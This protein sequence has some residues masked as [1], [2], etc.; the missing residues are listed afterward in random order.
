MTIS[1]RRRDLTHNVVHLLDER[2]PE[3]VDRPVR[4]AAR[5]AARR[6]Q[7]LA[8]RLEGLAYHLEGR[9]PDPNVDDLRLAQRVRSSLGPLE[10]RLD[11][12]RV[13]VASSDR[14]VVLHGVVDA[15]GQ[16]QELE[17]AAQR[18]AG[19]RGVRSRLHVGMG[20]GDTRPSEGRTTVQSSPAWR[21]LVGAARG[22][23]LSDDGSQR[24]AQAVL[25]TLL[26]CLPEGER[27]HVLAHLPEDVRMR[28]HPPLQVG[29]LAKPR[30]VQAFDAAVAERAQL[31]VHE[32]ALATRAVLDSLRGLVPEEVDDVE[33]VLPSDLKPLWASPSSTTIQT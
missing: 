9:R 30:T 12:P 23:G 7:R 21:E 20:P 33:A 2:L 10:K 15:P 8:G 5:W 11:L 26:D 25:A 29:R 17:E 27:Q 31:L 18:V 24:A 19:V 3:P 14:V 16:A 4:A 28:S 1:S 32:A 6:A 13:H 22:V